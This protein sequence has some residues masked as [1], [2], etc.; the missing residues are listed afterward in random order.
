MARGL[1]CSGVSGF[2]AFSDLGLW[3]QG[4]PRLRVQGRGAL[5]FRVPGFGVTLQIKRRRMQRA[6][7]QAVQSTSAKWYVALGKNF[8]ACG[9]HQPYRGGG[10]GKA[11]KAP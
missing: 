3:P 6:F 4:F 9:G 10:R 7:S 2:R 5:L 8:F 1:W 11:G